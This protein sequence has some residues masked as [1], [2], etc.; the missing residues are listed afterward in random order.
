[1]AVVV[2]L[3]L[4]RAYRTDLFRDD[5]RRTDPEHQRVLQERERARQARHQ[6][7]DETKRE[8]ERRRAAKTAARG[9]ALRKKASRRSGRE[10]T[11]A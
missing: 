7:A 1:M 5:W 10:H 9:E 3:M 6:A 11:P 2:F 4:R 8:R